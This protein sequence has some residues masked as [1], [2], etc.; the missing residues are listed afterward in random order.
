M[1]MI[2][3]P[4][5]QLWWLTMV[6]ATAAADNHRRRRSP[7]RPQ[8]AV[9]R[10]HRA[11]WILNLATQFCLWVCDNIYTAAV[12]A[13][14]AAAVPRPTRYRARLR[15]K[16]D[17][18]RLVG[19]DRRT[20]RFWGRLVATAA[21]AATAGRRVLWVGHHCG[22]GAALHAAALGGPRLGLFRQSK[23]FL[24]SLRAGRALGKKIKFKL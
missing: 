4:C 3:P 8:A 22:G 23:Q 24:H 11:N 6:A 2:P 19:D 16:V 7:L 15:G 1:I 14:A 21:A 12:F 13:V 18:W 9:G 20:F 5:L 17:R 10:R